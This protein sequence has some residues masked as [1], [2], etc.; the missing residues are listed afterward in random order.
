MNLLQG[1]CIFLGAVAIALVIMILILTALL[2]NVQAENRA[3]REHIT[4]L[5]ADNALLIED[6]RELT[7]Q[8]EQLQ[9]R[10]DILAA[11][12]KELTSR[13]VINVQYEDEQPILYYEQEIEQYAGLPEITWSFNRL[14]DAH[15]NTYR[16]EDYRL[17]ARGTEQYEIQRIAFTEPETGLRCVIIGGEQYYTV[18]LARAYGITLG[19]AWRVILRNGSQFNI[20][21]G[22][23][24]HPIMQ[25]RADD[26]GD[27]DV[28]YDEQDTISVIEFIYDEQA[29]PRKAKLAGTASYFEKFGGMY[30]DGGDIVKMEYIGRKWKP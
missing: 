8:N 26:F 22:D 3:V 7:R 30:G 6:K 12:A 25:A 20:L 11:M 1:V 17:F 14:P 23:Y 19:N 27:P 28:N 5:Q 13:A 2:H 9:E 16:C 29:M 24:K 21:H 10:N 15:T 18:A 4:R